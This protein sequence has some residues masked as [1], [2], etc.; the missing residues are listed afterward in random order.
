MILVDLDASEL[1]LAELAGA[2][3]QA[4]AVVRGYTATGQGT[5]ETHARGVACEIA[6]AKWLGVFYCPQFD[7]DHDLGD[8]C[9]L[10]VRSSRR[11]VPELH[12]RTSRDTR[13]RVAYVLVSPR[14]E[15]RFGICGWEWSEVVLARGRPST[16][17][18]VPT[19]CMV[20]AALQPPDTIRAVLRVPEIRWPTT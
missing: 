13:E 18:G 1:R 9:N 4:R 12:L 10:E 7:P 6:L 5:A 17:W 2:E 19:R 11:R 8:V 16:A 15:V 3:R 20:A 14:S